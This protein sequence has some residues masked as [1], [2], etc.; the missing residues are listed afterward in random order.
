VITFQRGTSTFVYRVAAVA[1]RGSH[2]LLHR[3]ER[4]DFWSLPGGRCEMGEP[5]VDAIRRE[6]REELGAEIQVERLLWVGEVFY[7]DHGR[8][9]HELSFYF[10]VS[11][12]PQFNRG[13]PGA[14]FYGDEEGLRLI[15]VWHPL[16]KLETCRL[17]PTFLR[18]ALR[19]LPQSTQ[20]VIHTGVA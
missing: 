7:A 8:D 15:F 3:S 20:H 17:Y 11:L 14:P 16:Q 6:M 18:T 10:L 13:A 5:S 9:Y 4:D 1:M 12:G 2:V 19:A